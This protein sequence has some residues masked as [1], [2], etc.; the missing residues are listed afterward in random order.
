MAEKLF[1][2]KDEPIEGLALKCRKIMQQEMATYG[3]DF[4]TND[5]THTLNIYL[6]LTQGCNLSC[7]YCYQSKE[8]KANPNLMS[9]E[10]IDASI[11]FAL[12]NFDEK[13]INFTLFGGEPF[14]KFDLIKYIIEKY[15]MFRYRIVTNGVILNEN[16]EIY[17]WVFEHK[18]QCNISVSISSLQQRYGSEFLQKTEKLVKLVNNNGGDIH[19][20]IDDPDEL[21]YQNIIKLYQTCDAVRVSC[22]RHFDKIKV[23]KEETK[24]LFQRLADYLYFGEKP[25]WGKST[26]D[27]GFTNNA[28]RRRKGLPLYDLPSTFCGCGGHLY[29]TINHLGDIYPCDFF[30]SFPETKMGDIYNGFNP[31]SYYI[32]SMSKWLERVYETCADC[33]LLPNKDLRLCSRALCFAEN[34]KVNGHPFLPTENHCYSNEIEFC[35]YDYIAKKAIETKLD[36]VYQRTV[37]NSKGRK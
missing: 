37:G 29:L 25:I 5:R 27:G 34:Y 20:V 17:D 9:K 1:T 32:K 36:E 13:L 16:Q 26:F 15:P 30:V 19:Y 23:T 33:K 6:L 28:Y 7:P 35:T 12:K 3:V 10:V 31:D 8:F 14:L 18:N 4:I 21:A 22:T 2:L 24:K 11:K